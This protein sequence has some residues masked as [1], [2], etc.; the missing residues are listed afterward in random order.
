MTMVRTFQTHNEQYPQIVITIC[1]FWM[2]EN[3]SR[4]ICA[5]LGCGKAMIDMCG[6]AGVTFLLAQYV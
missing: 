2:H 5:N 6:Q 3:Y 1:P 4:N